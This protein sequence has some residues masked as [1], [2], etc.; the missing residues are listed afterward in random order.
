M[1]FERI[2][3]IW[4]DFIVKIKVYMIDT[5]LKIVKGPFSHFHL[6]QECFHF[7]FKNQFKSQFVIPTY[8]LNVND[9]IHKCIA[10]P[11]E[12]FIEF[13]INYVM[14]N[15]YRWLMGSP[16]PVWVGKR[17][18]LSREGSSS[19]HSCCDKGLR[20]LRSHPKDHPH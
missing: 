10:H 20:F 12:N 19:C 16:L 2:L 1:L 6:N 4:N 8:S 18:G 14:M 5:S 17:P 3:I 15:L 11:I 13:C 7:I 9:N